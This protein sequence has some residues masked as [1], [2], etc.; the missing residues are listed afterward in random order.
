[1]QVTY[2]KTASKYVSSLD[3]PT[4]LRIRQGIEG[5]TF[6]PPKGDIKLLQGKDNI[7]R[8]R[9]GKYRIL[10]YYIELVDGN[11]GLNITHIGSRGEIY[12]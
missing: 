3:K 2:S 11:I 7:Y 10:Y 4:K 6:E 8:L 5:L 9:I 1:M 12:K